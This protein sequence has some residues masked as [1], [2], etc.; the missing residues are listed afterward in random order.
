MA[1]GKVIG[2]LEIQN[3]IVDVFS[4]AEFASDLQNIANKYGLQPREM[5]QPSR[6]NE[7]IF[8]YQTL[9]GEGA[10]WPYLC[11]VWRNEDVQTWGRQD[12]ATERSRFD[13]IFGIR[14][15]SMDKN[16]L[17]SVSLAYIDAAKRCATRAVRT[18][19]I[20]DCRYVSSNEGTIFT[21]SSNS[22]IRMVTI[23]IDVDYLTSTESTA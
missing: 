5:A 13:L 20:T 7:D 9:Q 12:M 15:N 22:L 10:T 19:D 16:L 21:G 1:F 11:I 3:R 23:S 2:I 17:N 8:R 18:N 4:G 6:E 14:L